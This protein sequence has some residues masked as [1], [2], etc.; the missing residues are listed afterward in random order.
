MLLVIC[1]PLDYGDG[2]PC[3]PPYPLH[4]A[5]CSLFIKQINARRAE[6]VGGRCAGSPGGEGRAR[7]YRA[8]GRRAAARALTFPFAT[9][10]HLNLRLA[11]AR[12]RASCS[13]L[14]KVQCRFWLLLWYMVKSE[15]RPRESAE[16]T[17]NGTKPERKAAKSPPGSRESPRI[18]AGRRGRDVNVTW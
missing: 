3:P 8:R 2:W 6:E 9:A 4:L 14:A 16:K 10:L 15:A 12:N 5:R 1:L 17:A 7:V 11:S 13:S 18:Q